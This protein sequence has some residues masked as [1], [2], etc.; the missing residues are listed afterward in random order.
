M[1]CWSKCKK[2]WRRGWILKVWERAEIKG[3]GKDHK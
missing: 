3:K 1:D 2:D